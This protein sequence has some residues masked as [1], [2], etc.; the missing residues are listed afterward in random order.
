MM[1]IVW[2]GMEYILDFE[3]DS[4]SPIA[5]GYI[6]LRGITGQGQMV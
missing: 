3:K 2:Q 4:P 5:A 6:S 1:G